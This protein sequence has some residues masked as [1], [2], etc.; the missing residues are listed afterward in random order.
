VGTRT[1]LQVRSHGQIKKKVG[2]DVVPFFPEWN[3]IYSLLVDYKTAH[4][5]CRVPTRFRTDEGVE[6]GSWVDRQR[7][8]HADGRLSEERVNQLEEIGFVWNANEAAWEENYSRL[9][10]F[11]AIH[12]HCDVPHSHQEEEGSGAKLYPW[13]NRQ[14]S[15]RSAGTL[16]ASREKRLQALGFCWAV[17]KS[18]VGGGWDKKFEALEKYRRKHGNCRVPRTFVT[19]EGVNLG[20]WVRTQR[21]SFWACTLDKE[22]EKKLEGLGFTWDVLISFSG[23]SEE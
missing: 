9:E 3:E 23:S 6:L 7:M 5:T 15:S 18:G 19:A 4:G 2:K 14:R 12:G 8:S 10:R 21:K 13:V 11:V 22:R 20:N 16:E 17:K 1:E